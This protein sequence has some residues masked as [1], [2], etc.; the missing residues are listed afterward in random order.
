MAIRFSII[1]PVLHEAPVINDLL[2][3]L[4]KLTAAGESELLVVDGSPA[5]DTLGAIATGS[6]RCLSSPPGRARQMNAGAGAAAGEILIFL[7]ADTRLPVDA[8]PLIGQAMEE[9]ACLGGAFDLAIDSP[10]FIYRLIA[11]LASLRSRFTCIPYGDQAIFLR[12]ETFRL[13]GGYPEIPIM[14]DV[15]LMQSLKKKGGR[16]RI[17][18]RCVVTSPRRWEKE[19][20]FYTTLRNWCLLIAYSRGVAPEKLARYYRNW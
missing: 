1:I 9:P 5:K 19:G 17:I 20:L 13:L 8:L 15:A 7:H 4:Q 11:A 12:R 10:R 2:E 18:R 3:H 6:V 16:I 14:E